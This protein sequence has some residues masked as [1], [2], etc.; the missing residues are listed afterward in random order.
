ML[1]KMLDYGY[2]VLRAGVTRSICTA[3]LHPSLGLHHHNRA[4]AFCLVDDLIEPFR[5]V[6]DRL[7]ARLPSDPSKTDDLTSTLKRQLAGFLE[8]TLPFEGESRTTADASFRSATSLAG[9]F[10]GEREKLS[11]PWIG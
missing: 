4:N 9:V 7:I 3:G 10:L 2:A 5:P 8:E 1:N 11:L 6:L